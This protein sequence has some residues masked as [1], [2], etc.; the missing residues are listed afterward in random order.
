MIA[1]RLHK[2]HAHVDWPLSLLQGLKAGR[3]QVVGLKKATR[4]L[5]FQNI[6]ALLD[7]LPA[8]VRIAIRQSLA[9]H[10]AGNSIDRA[11][12]Q[13]DADIWLN[14]ARLRDLPAHPEAVLLEVVGRDRYG[15]MHRLQPVAARALKRLR[16]AALTQNIVLEVIS[17][18]RSQKDQARILSRKRLFGQ[19]WEQILAVN[20]P[21]GFSE[22]HSG[23]AI[24]FAV[25]GEMALTEA[26]EQSAAFAWLSKNATRFGFVLSSP[27]D[28]PCGFVYEPWHWCFRP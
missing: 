19:S 6:R 21:P 8:Q 5:H 4:G 9:G 14:A 15:R 20:A 16:E 10:S 7:A 12:A 13:A 18:F 22:H 26:F 3:L 24:D 1:S 11:S 2:R 17:S 25:P 23:C 27:R 28:N